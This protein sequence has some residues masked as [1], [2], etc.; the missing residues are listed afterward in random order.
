M[1]RSVPAMGLPTD[2]RLRDCRTKMVL[3]DGLDGVLPARIRDRRDKIGFATAESEWI[4]NEPELF[5]GL[6]EEAIAESFGILNGEARR[7]FEEVAAGTRD[8]N[9]DRFVWRWICFARWLRVF[10]VRP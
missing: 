7:M 10:G 1:A 9:Q 2:Y 8:H 3:R 5:R 4:R 6:V